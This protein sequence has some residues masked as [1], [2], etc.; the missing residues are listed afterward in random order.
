M[1]PTHVLLVR[2][3]AIG[4]GVHLE[5]ELGHEV[6]RL[7]RRCEKQ[8]PHLHRTVVFGVSGDVSARVRSL[9]SG[10]DAFL[11]KPAKLSDVCSLLKKYG[12]VRE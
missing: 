12:T 4:L 10:M 3:A 1:L 7:L 2:Q 8:A 11:Q 5:N 9:S 6:V